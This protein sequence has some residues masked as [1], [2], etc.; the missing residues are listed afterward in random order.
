MIKVIGLD[1]AKNVFQVHGIDEAG[2]PVLRRKL[3]R[4]DVLRLF[5]H[6][7]PALVGHRGLSHG[8]SLG[9]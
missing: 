9:A 2:R 1:I 6:L 4:A 8:A 7:E 3:R 5:S